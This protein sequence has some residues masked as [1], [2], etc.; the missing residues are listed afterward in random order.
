MWF[1]RP[2][3]ALAAVTALITIVASDDTK[4]ERRL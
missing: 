3:T 2:L 1:S 4:A